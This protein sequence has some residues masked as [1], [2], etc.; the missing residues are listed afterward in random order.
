MRYIL[1]IKKFRNL[2]IKALR[3]WATLEMTSHSIFCNSLISEFL[4]S[5]ICFGLNYIMKGPG[6]LSRRALSVRGLRGE[7]QN[8]CLLCQMV[9]VYTVIAAQPGER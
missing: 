1:F 5:S 7:W 4:N 2:G 9:S 8:R 6:V 3:D